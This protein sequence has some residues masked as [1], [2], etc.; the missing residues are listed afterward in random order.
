MAAFCVPPLR[1]FKPLSAALPDPGEFLMSDF[2]KFERPALLHVGF[3][4]VEAFEVGAM[5][6]RARTHTHQGLIS[7]QPHTHTRAHAHSRAHTHAHAF[8]GA[9]WG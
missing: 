4:A 8:N 1:R 7:G 9:A 6:A 3:Q 5:H 2:S